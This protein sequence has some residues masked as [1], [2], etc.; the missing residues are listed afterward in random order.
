[1]HCSRCYSLMAKDQLLVFEGATGRMWMDGYRCMNCGQIQ[2][3]PVQQY[4]L[5]RRKPT[6]IHSHDEQDYQ[7]EDVHLGAESFVMQAA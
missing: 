3:S 7:G 1:M 6:S 5:S 4:H 2:E